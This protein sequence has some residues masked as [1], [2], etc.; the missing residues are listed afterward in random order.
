MA[1]VGG[2]H[3]RRLVRLLQHL[4]SSSTA[5]S[6]TTSPAQQE[7]PLSFQLQEPVFQDYAWQ[8]LTEEQVAAYVNQIETVGNHVS[9]TPHG[10]YRTRPWC[11]PS[12]PWG[13]FAVY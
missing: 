3:R 10:T 13:Y 4:Q 2:R 6:S 11:I 8:P 1:Q 7:Q 5:A 12:V 9:T